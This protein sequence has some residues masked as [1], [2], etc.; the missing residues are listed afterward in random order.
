MREDNRQ[1]Y[2]GHRAENI[3][4]LRH[5]GVNMIKVDTSRKASVRSKQ[6]MAAM[7]TAHFEA[8]L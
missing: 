5:I 3:A 7:D 2:S 1:I 8:I 4:R 6:H